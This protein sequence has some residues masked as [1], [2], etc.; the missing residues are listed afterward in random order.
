MISTNPNTTSQSPNSPKNNHHPI[1]I[2]TLIKH[3]KI[4]DTLSS[5]LTV[6]LSS[7]SRSLFVSTE[8]TLLQ[9]NYQS[10]LDD[11]TQEPKL[12]DYT[13]KFNCSELFQEGQWLHICL[14]LTRAV[15][16]NSTCSLYINSNLIETKKLHYIN[17]SV[18]ASGAA[19]PAS[20]SIHA[21]IGT[22]PLYRFQS[23]VVW[24]QACCYLFEDVLNPNTI[25]ILYQ[26]GPNYLGSFQ[27]PPSLSTDQESGQDMMHDS[28][29]SSSSTSN[30]TSN[31]S[32]TTAQLNTSLIAEEK[33]IFGLHAQ[34]QFDMTL[35]KFRRI[36][37]KNDSKAIG[38][39]LNIPSNESVT[40]LHILSNTSAQLSGPARTVGGVV[41]GYLGVRTFQPMPV[42]KSIE[43]IGGVQFLL[44]LIAMSSDIEFMYGS[45]K[46]LVCIM[47]SNVEIMREMDRLNGY[48]LL[49]MLYKRKKHLINSHILNLT[50]SL[51][52]GDDM[53]CPREQQQNNN[54]ALLT[55]VNVKAFEYLLCDL[56]IWYNNPQPD[57][58]RS[59]HE[60]FNELLIMNESAANSRLFHRF[61]MLKRILN[62]IKE[63]QRTV[64]SNGR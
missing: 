43:H 27:S 9:S 6:Y 35:A 3:S 44:G 58:Q 16:K 18:G 4:K 25:N 2:L 53:M 13:V 31:S 38:K 11:T 30:T 33:I 48:Q 45:V 63:P 59:L 55:I 51:V 64:N 37:N 17:S 22:L 23:P 32:I 49:G 62:M 7:K 46:A 19:A 14:V 40:P 26:L 5:C 34:K 15:L 29:S 1:R 52:T 28:S 56:D 54:Q 41:I 20:T 10:K 61:G 39:Q 42:S 57:I 12:N 50:F 8:E 60:R 21:C 24:R 36:Y 47:K